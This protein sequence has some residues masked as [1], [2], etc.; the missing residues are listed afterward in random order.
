MMLAA[1]CAVFTGGADTSFAAAPSWNVGSGTWDD[2]TTGNWSPAQVP[3]AG[4]SVTINRAAATTVEF[5]SGNFTSAGTSLLTLTLGGTGASNVLQVG[6]GDILC[7]T[8]T[9]NVNSG[10]RLEM[11]GG[12]IADAYTDWRDSLKVNNGA[13]ASVTGGTYQLQRYGHVYVADTAGH[14]ASLI[15]SGTGK[16][17]APTA[18]NQ[19]GA[20]LNAR[21]GNSTVTVSEN[22]EL[23]IWRNIY[24]GTVSGTH[25]WTV[26]GGTLREQFG[27][28]A[29]AGF[30]LGGGSGSVTLTQTGGTVDARML[31]VASNS[32]YQLDG[33]KLTGGTVNI[34]GGEMNVT[35]GLVDLQYDVGPGNTSG[36]V[37]RLNISGGS[38]SN[39]Y[40]LVG[41]S[42]SG[43]GYGTPGGR[44]VVHQ[45]G[46]E[47]VIKGGAFAVGHS[48]NLSQ[49]SE[50]IWEGGQFGT[51]D[52][53]WPYWY[54]EPGSSFRGRGKP[55]PDH[56]AYGNLRMSGRVI[57]DGFNTETN[58]DLSNLRD[59]FNDIDNPSDGTNGW[60]AVRGGKLILST[61]Y[62]VNGNATGVWGEAQGQVPVQDNDLDLVNSARI[63]F[64][65]AAYH[66]LGGAL[67]ASDRSDV[68]SGLVRPI[69][70]WQLSSGSFTD[71][72]VTFRY[73]HGTLAA[74]GLPE[75]AIRLRRHTGTAWEKVTGSQ[76]LAKHWLTSTVLLPLGSGQGYLGIFAID[77]PRTGTMVTIL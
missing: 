23:S 59:L 5:A 4:D 51:K 38:I 69:G 33:G 71:A 63:I 28:Q 24:V 41:Q 67:F 26:S 11:S 12:T 52:G 44:A 39:R 48:N 8:N 55:T 35:A 16:L 68:P 54:I 31:N 19:T 22:G 13:S 62:S 3:V 42:P 43:S 17:V 47:V 32:V 74:Q 60:Y 53:A 76:D 18:V 40:F 30:V 73:D 65:G 46:G 77:V 64:T 61:Y 20:D 57:A 9:F 25:T 7:L 36:T 70:V 75:N 1:V 72:T 2:T 58:L 50:Y 15:V 66:K 10:G 56:A 45:T 49:V 27:D 6:A 21:R 14:T 29:Y 37:S 34:K